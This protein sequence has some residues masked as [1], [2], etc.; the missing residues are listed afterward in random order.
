[1]R[2]PLEDV[3]V[4][5]LTHVWFGP[6][7]TMMLAYLG[8]EV[9]R[10][11][12]PWGGIDRVG[13]GPLFGGVT[14]TFH[15]LNLNKKDLTLNLKHPRGREIFLRLV[16][17]SD[18]VV[19]NFRPGT[20]ERLG[21]DYP[22]LREVNPGIIYAALSGF[23][24]YG[25]YSRRGSY[26]AVAEAMSGH[27]RLTGDGVDPEGPPV[28]MAQA[29]GD[30]GPGTM[31]A[32]AIVAAL[33][34]RDKTGV[35]Q[36]IDVAQLDCMVAYNTAVTGYLLSGLKPWEM[37]ERYPSPGVG[38]LMRTRDGG[39]IKVAAYSPRILDRLREALGV[40]ELSK[41]LVEGRVAEMTRDE[42]VDFFVSIDVP[43]APVYH[44]DE[45]VR[46]RH[47]WE[48]GMFIEVEHPKAGRVR[49]TNFPLKFSKYS[50]PHPSAAP[51]LGQ[52]NGEIL[53][54]LLGYTEEQVSELRREGVIG[55][56]A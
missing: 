37:R 39:W 36:M 29:Y 4:L 16:E 25:P 54:D 23:G 10:I 47:L 38:G 51:L 27:T 22:T 13:F 7:C 30:L 41:E 34:M 43:V 8:A 48:R 49:T 6:W 21:L 15:H 45:V 14:Y 26:A 44:L 1:M 33:R 28:E 46:D 11:E 20:M 12:P 50:P 17:V 32:M 35:G 24:Q 53:I 5:D 52:N 42:A 2:S 31:A 3:R 56:E 9:I 18:V 40:E 55:G 19:E